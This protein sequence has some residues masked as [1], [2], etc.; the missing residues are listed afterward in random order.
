MWS[1]YRHLVRLSDAV[2]IWA[3]AIVEQQTKTNHL[4]ESFLAQQT[5]R[6]QNAGLGDNRSLLLASDHR[7]ANRD[8]SS[9]ATPS[10]SQPHL[11]LKETWTLNP[12]EIAIFNPTINNDVETFC[13]RIK[14]VADSRGQLAVCEVLQLCLR[15]Y[16]LDWYVNLDDVVLAQLRVS[17]EAWINQLRCRFGMSLTEAFSALVRSRYDITSDYDVYHEQKIRLARIA[18]ITA[19]ALVVQHLF[20]GQ[21]CEKVCP[22]K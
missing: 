13:R 21:T 20:E 16:A 10:P 8:D 11:L 12:N 22:S 14:H 1:A 6:M 3:R 19:P 7:S 4:L 5:A 15:S 9:L 18:G 17:T 2:L